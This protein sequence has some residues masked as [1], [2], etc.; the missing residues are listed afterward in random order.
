MVLYM[1]KEKQCYKD[2]ID[3]IYYSYV[4]PIIRHIMCI[5]TFFIT[6]MLLD[7]LLS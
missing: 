5:N 7:N 3:L 4:I 2:S 6:G 1:K